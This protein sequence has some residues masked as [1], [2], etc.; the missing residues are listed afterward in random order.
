MNH[1]QGLIFF[2]TLVGL[3]IISWS[4]VLYLN[5]NP[6]ELENVSQLEAQFLIVSGFFVFPLIILIALIPSGYYLTKEIKK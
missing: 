3:T 2:W 1:L 6:L 5:L 4:R